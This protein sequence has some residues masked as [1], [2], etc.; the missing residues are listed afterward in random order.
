MKRI[1]KYALSPEAQVIKMPWQSNIVAFD[2]QHGVPTIWA[3]CDTDET[4]EV[5]IQVTPQVTGG[6]VP[7]DHRHVGTALLNSGTFVLHYYI[8]AI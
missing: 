2:V 3:E 1:L 8:K 6:S 5:S 7:E 4:R